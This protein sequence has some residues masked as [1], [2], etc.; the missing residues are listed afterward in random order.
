MAS[1][2]EGVLNLQQFIGQL[3]AANGAL[4]EITKALETSTKDLSQLE[5]EAAE[6]G[7][8]LNEGLDQLGSQLDSGREEATEA[9][10]EVAEVT[11]DAQD[12]L[13]DARHQVEEAAGDFE[14][15]SQAVVTDLEERH[16]T[17]TE[18]GFEDLA[19][20]VDEVQQ[21][22]DTVRESS[23]QAFSE[24]EGAVRGFEAETQASWDAAD[25]A[26]EQNAA[27]LAGDES[28][29]AS[30]VSEYVEAFESASAD[31][32]SACSRLEG[33]LASIYESG[34]A[35][36]DAAGQELA[37]GWQVLSQEAV[38]FVDSGV[39]ER[40]EEPARVVEEEALGGLKQEYTALG[41]ALEEGSATA[42]ELAPLAE[43]L[44]KSQA[45]IGHVDELMQALA[46]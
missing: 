32:G 9:I 31:L 41:G 25:G 24:L 4:E 15:R 23:E 1:L 46:G 8:G 33:E 13:G 30:D 34:R 19:R 20:T 10:E 40:L 2:D 36:V 16:A 7:G 42:Q 44:A 43:Q 28:S 27:E 45:I 14:E 38:A 35:G 22:C 5:D 39:Q 29:L 3:N 26:V 21:A 37:G 18:R 12:T 17:L 6:Q 11:R